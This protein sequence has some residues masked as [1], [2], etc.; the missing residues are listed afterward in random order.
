M[1]DAD[2]CAA[3]LAGKI[4]VHLFKS[5]WGLEE[6]VM[7]RRCGGIFNVGDFFGQGATS[8]WEYVGGPYEE[9]AFYTAGRKR[10]MLRCTP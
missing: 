5:R 3:V 10:K 7:C 2:R 1:T 6:S 9:D 4:I 8:D